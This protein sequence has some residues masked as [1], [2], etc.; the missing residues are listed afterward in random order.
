TQ[1]GRA[2]NRYPYSNPM[3]DMTIIAANGKTQSHQLF[4]LGGTQPTGVGDPFQGTTGRLIENIELSDGNGGPN[5]S[6]AWSIW[7]RL[8]QTTSASHALALPDGNI[9]SSGGG[10]AGAATN[11]VN[12]TPGVGVECGVTIFGPCTDSVSTYAR[13]VNIK[14]Q[15]VCINAA[16]Y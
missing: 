3:V 6:A 13:A 9:F 12:I 5:P 8:I 2:H 16:P 4:L 14:N 1:I 15:I 10:G 11:R 7:G